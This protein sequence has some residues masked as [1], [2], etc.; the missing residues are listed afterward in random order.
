MSAPSS[1]YAS[2]SPGVA[3]AAPAL[4]GSRWIIGGPADLALIVLTPLLAGPLLWGAHA[5][6]SWTEI[7][8]FVATFCATGHHLPGMIR[9]YGD[10][11]L[12]QRFR[13]RFTIVPALLVAACVY[14]SIVGL[15][16]VFLISVAW[17]MWHGMM[18]TYGFLRIYDA[19]AGRLDARMARLDLAMCVAW[20]GIGTIW[21]TPR[22]GPLLETFYACGGPYLGVELLSATRHVWV[23]GTVLVT[24]VY[25]K[26]LLEHGARTQ[27]NPIKLTLMAV[28]FASWWVTGVTIA[29]PLVG[30]AIFELFHDVQYLAIVWMFNLKRVDMDSTVGGFTRFLFRRSGALVG[31]YVGLVLAYGSLAFVADGFD[32]STLKKTLE[33]L[34]VTSALLHF[35]Y[36]GFIWKLR[37]P[38]TRQTLGSSGPERVL[39]RIA[40]SR[41]H[42]AAWAAFVLPVVLLGLAQ[43]Y[44][45]A[46]KIE[47][48]RALTDALPDYAQGQFELGRALTVA[49]RDGEAL[50]P[51][52]VA[53]A[54]QPDHREAR[55]SLEMLEAR[56]APAAERIAHCRAAIE[57]APAKIAGHLCLGAALAREGHGDDAVAA[58]REAVR[59]QP[60]RA[61]AHFQLATALERQ[62]VLD[63]ALSHHRRALELATEGGNRKLARRVE[64]HL[65]EIGQRTS[66]PASLR[67]F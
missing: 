7:S 63:E 21:S 45:R 37:E 60:E 48:Y 50:E 29:H 24:L 22:L 6:W 36:D 11:A 49:D 5:R 39:G 1:A 14:S 61:A 15:R 66:Q 64:R 40:S 43:S 26:A 67:S 44:D 35:Y 25:A 20:F 23:L 58:F 16:G 9:A 33:G 52:R 59:V 65:G 47:R 55:F 51:L 18:Q 41:Q 34:L 57:A 10:R 19:R 2:T 32:A 42:G 27:W 56:R 62:G 13:A 46:P 3:T 53:L 12:F 38:E 31:A 8:L 4:R 54:V 28:S 30:E 17:A